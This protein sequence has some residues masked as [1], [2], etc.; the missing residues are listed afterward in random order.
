[1]R[2][3]DHELDCDADALLRAAGAHDLTTSAIESQNR[4]FRRHTTD[5]RELQC[6]AGLADALDDL[7]MGTVRHIAELTGASERQIDFVSLL[8]S[9]YSL[10]AIAR[11]TQWSRPTVTADLRSLCARMRVLIEHYPYWGLAELLRAL[12]TLDSQWR[13][14]R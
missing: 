8:A 13:V 10:S 9:G 2:G 5:L 1:M 3:A 4:L 6:T 12:W 14:R 7:S 11:A